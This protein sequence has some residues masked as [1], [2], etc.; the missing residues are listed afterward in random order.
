MKRTVVLLSGGLDSA[1]TLAIAKQ[2]GYE[3]Y[4]I[5]F[6]YGQ[7][8]AY[9]LQQAQKLAKSL[10]VAQHLILEVDLQSLGGSALTGDIAVPKD[11]S[12]EEMSTGIPATYVPAR[13][14]IFLTMALGWA[15]VLGADD[16]F[17]GVNALDYG[18]YPDCRPEYITAFEKV[19][20]LATKTGVEGTQHFKVHTPLIQSD[21][22]SIIRQ[23]QALRIDFNLTSS[24][25]DPNDE[26]IACGRCDACLLRQHGFAE[27]GITDPIAYAAA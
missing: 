6:R 15:E 12:Q 18:G 13:N 4:A 26:G 7:R 23:A 22:A 5:S 25:Y 19:A 14:T 27:A 21:K 3:V 9:E 10:G 8:H 11:R 20:N 1:T 17:I 24:C 2:Q 16:I